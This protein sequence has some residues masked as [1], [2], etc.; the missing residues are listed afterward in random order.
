MS[1]SLASRVRQEAM[2]LTTA[3]PS[4]ERLQGQQGRTCPHWGARDW[5]FLSVA[6][7][8]A[9]AV[10]L[11]FLGAPTIIDSSEGYYSEGAREMFESG[12]FITPHL[13][14]KPWFEKPILTY[15]LIAGS[16][17]LLGVNEL[18]ARLPAALC[19]V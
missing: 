11:P 4:T 2:R 14:Y 18:A 10:F 12:D 1:G 19:G 7:V 6:I 3:R 16:Y 17:G 13:N 15:W 9:V 5:L 8:A